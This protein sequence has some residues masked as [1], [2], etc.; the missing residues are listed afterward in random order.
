[1]G[2]AP[3]AAIEGEVV[4]VAAGVLVLVLLKPVVSALRSLYDAAAPGASEVGEDEEQLREEGRS[5]RAEPTHVEPLPPP[6]GPPGLPPQASAP[7]GHRRLD[8][9]TVMLVF[10]TLAVFT[11]GF[12]VILGDYDKVTKA[13]VGG[14]LTSAVTFWLGRAEGRREP[15]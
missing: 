15:A 9:T 12:I 2:S 5:E 13:L 8:V 1:V 7:A 6:P 10:I 4:A 14:L 11:L 3:L